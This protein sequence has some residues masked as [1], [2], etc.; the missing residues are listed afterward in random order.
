MWED[1]LPHYAL[2]FSFN[3]PIKG[4]VIVKSGFQGD[5]LFWWAVTCRQ[6][7]SS[8][9]RDFWSATCSFYC[10]RLCPRCPTQ[11]QKMTS[12]RFWACPPS[13]S[14]KLY[15]STQFGTA[16]PLQPKSW[17][18]VSAFGADRILLS[19]RAKAVPT[20]EMQPLLV[21]EVFLL[22]TYSYRVTVNKAHG[23]CT[24]L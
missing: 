11:T 17:V 21:F 6:A 15:L 16:W 12:L 8:G 5:G 18:L 7:S 14:L 9:L 24:Y 23:S 22:K 10:H 4:L 3:M 20:V 19:P 13:L 1:A 2:F